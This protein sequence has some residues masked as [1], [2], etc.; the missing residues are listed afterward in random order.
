MV[1]LADAKVNDIF[2]PESIDNFTEWIGGG[3]E[4]QSFG[5]HPRQR[6]CVNAGYCMI[7]VQAV[8][9]AVLRAAP[10]SPM[11]A[12][13]ATRNNAAR[14]DATTHR[15][16]SAVAVAQHASRVRLA[17]VEAAVAEERP[18]AALLAAIILTL[19]SVAVV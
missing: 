5:L 16:K 19:Q 6:Q 10:A 9:D 7:H 3:S 12:V 14:R 8:L 13:E 1:S 17:S 18:S 11:V 2:L 15:H 4:L